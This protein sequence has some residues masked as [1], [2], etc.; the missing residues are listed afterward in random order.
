MIDSLAPRVAQNR[1]EL[2]QHSATLEVAPE[3]VFDDL[4]WLATQICCVPIA[5][6]T[7][8]DG[9]HCRVK[10]KVGLPLDAFAGEFPFHQLVLEQRGLLL[11]SDATQDQRLVKNSLVGANGG[12][13]FFAGL[14][15]T[16]R[17]GSVLGVLS[18]LDRV[19]RQ[20]SPSQTYGLQVLA[21]Q[22]TTQFEQRPFGS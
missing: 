22:L 8:G 5:L 1:Y 6:I 3:K 11:V 2:L 20:L 7:L 21:R 19:P 15:L 4:A 10:S 16:T 12:I 18:V 13:R 17:T 14:P 9:H